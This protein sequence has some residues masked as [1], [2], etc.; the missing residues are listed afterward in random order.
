MSLNSNELI[1]KIN[2]VRASRYLMNRQ[3][4]TEHF[5]LSNERA[6]V[7]QIIHEM[8]FAYIKSK[9]QGCRIRPGEQNFS[10][11]LD[12]EV[13]QKARK[14]REV[15]LQNAEW[16]RWFDENHRNITDTIANNHNAFHDSNYVEYSVTEDKHFIRVPFVINRIRHYSSEGLMRLFQWLDDQYQKD[17]RL[18]NLYPQTVQLMEQ[19]IA[20]REEARRQRIERERTQYLASLHNRLVKPIRPSDVDRS[21]T[22]A[23]AIFKAKM[24]DWCREQGRPPAYTEEITPQVILPIDTGVRVIAREGERE[25]D[26]YAVPMFGG[27]EM[28]EGFVLK[29]RWGRVSDYNTTDKRSRDGQAPIVL[30]GFVF[31]SFDIAHWAHTIPTEHRELLAATRRFREEANAEAAEAARRYEE[32]REQREAAAR[33]QKEA[34]LEARHNELRERLI[35]AREVVVE[36]PAQA[37]PA[38]SYAEAFFNPKEEAEEEEDDFFEDEEIHEEEEAPAPPERTPAMDALSDSIRSQMSRRTEGLLQQLETLQHQTGVYRN[39]RGLPNER[40]IFVTSSGHKN[41]FRTK[42][43]A[44]LHARA[45][46]LDSSRMEYIYDYWQP[47]LTV[48]HFI[49]R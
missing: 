30:D 45:V 12:A 27:Y 6:E 31:C 9:F 15:I 26:W 11:R 40:Y 39:S 44:C 20:R 28:P 33:A 18:A 2:L 25:K 22:S 47:T 38:P 24:Y 8:I 23:E 34:E 48:E 19:E 17:V 42:E 16:K 13:H 10:V 37:T 43:E 14:L 7:E 4:V 41:F 29:D 21:N 49:R 5:P 36:T 3:A 1:A 32:E 35:R 46:G